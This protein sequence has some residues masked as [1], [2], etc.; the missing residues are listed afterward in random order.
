MCVCVVVCVCV[1]VFVCVCEENKVDFNDN[2]S[3]DPERYTFNL[4]GTE[5]ISLEDKRKV[6]HHASIT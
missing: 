1:C 2:R 5:P 6:G 4:T 3:V